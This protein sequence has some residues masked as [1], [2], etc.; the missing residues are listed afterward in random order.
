MCIRDRSV[1]DGMLT[2]YQQLLR[3]RPVVTNVASALVISCTGD[4]LAQRLESDSPHDMG[5]SAVM[6]T[7]SGLVFTP[8]FMTFYRIVDRK[9]PQPSVLNALRKSVLAVGGLGLPVNAAFLAL[10]T[11][12]EY[13]LLG[14]IQTQAEYKE[15]L[16]SKLREDVVRIWSSSALF[17]GPTNV[18]NF[19]LVP[20][21]FRVIFTSVAS[22]CW[23]TYLSLVQHEYCNAEK[24][25]ADGESREIPLA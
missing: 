4:A 18:V 23:N 5:R 10:S 17:W 16:A 20:G 14:Q 8:T 13:K 21:Q 1:A 7:Y 15:T 25:V 6:M 2:A 9:W 3:R 11:T 24:S 22:V 12:L 19:A